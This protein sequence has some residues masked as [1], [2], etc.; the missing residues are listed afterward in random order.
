M[1]N[2]L[3][4]TSDVTQ[5]PEEALYQLKGVNPPVNNQAVVTSTASDKTLQS[6]SKMILTGFPDTKPELPKEL[7]PY[8]RVRD[9]L[10]TYD[11]LVYMGNRIVVPEQLRVE[12][13]ET[14]HV[15]HQ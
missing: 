4:Y 14:L 13:L 2:S 1:I 7:Q 9:A 11:G 3:P 10:T 15:A 6:L 8:W 12:I 5:W